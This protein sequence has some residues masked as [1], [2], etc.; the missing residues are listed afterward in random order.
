MFQARHLVRQIAAYDIGFFEEPLRAN[1]I[2]RLADFRR[3]AP[4]PI[5][6]GQNEG[7]LSRW[8]DILENTPSIFCNSTSAPTPTSTCIFT[9][10]SPTAACANGT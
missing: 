7:Q 5:V 4:M 1:D 3:E 6:A 10:A 2:H 8:R 9:P